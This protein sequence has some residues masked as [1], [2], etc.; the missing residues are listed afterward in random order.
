MKYHPDKNPG[1][2]EA[3]EKFKEVSTAYAVLSDPNKVYNVD[4]TRCRYACS[5]SCIFSGLILRY[6]LGLGNTKKISQ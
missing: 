6:G 1:N 3:S 4:V 5:S 2:E